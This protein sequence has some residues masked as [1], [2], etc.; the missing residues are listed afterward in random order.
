VQAEAATLDYSE[1]VRTYELKPYVIGD[2]EEQ[3][4][5]E[6]FKRQDSSALYYPRVWRVEFFRIQSTFPQVEGEPAHDVSDECILV[7][8][9]IEDWASL[10]ATS[11]E[12]CMEQ[13]IAVIQKDVGKDPA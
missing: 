8:H 7:Q 13:V 1:L 4:R 9:H 3:L 10:T 12:S 2:S 11:I 6:I 5:V